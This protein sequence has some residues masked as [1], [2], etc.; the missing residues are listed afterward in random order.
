MTLNLNALYSPPSAILISKL[1]LTCE[2]RVRKSANE[3]GWVST[4]ALEEIVTEEVKKVAEEKDVETTTKDVIAVMNV[5]SVAVN[6]FGQPIRTCFG[7]LD[8]SI[9]DT[10]FATIF[11]AANVNIMAEAGEQDPSSNLYTRTDFMRIAELA[12]DYMQ[13]HHKSYLK[14][15]G[16]HPPHDN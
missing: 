15:S 10:V 13:L 11:A 8:M 16:S 4:E 9:K 6:V 12:Y 3:S 1:L 7:E 2:E 14:S 5:K